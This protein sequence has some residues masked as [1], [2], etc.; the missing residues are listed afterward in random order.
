MK[1]YII[2]GEASGDLHA[3]NL[4]KEIRA[5]DEHAE[6]RCW[7]GD[8]MQGQGGNLMKHY[9][10]LA[11]M[12]FLEVALN[13]RKIIGNLDF[14]RKDIMVW[15]PDAVI[16]VDYPGFNL[17]IAEFCHKQGIKVFYYIS[18]QVWAWKKSRIKNIVRDVDRLFVI[19][20]FEKKFYKE[21]HYDVDFVGHPL[22][23]A[24]DGSHEKN[25]SVAFRTKHRLDDRKIIALLPGSRKQEISKILPIM[26]QAMTHFPDFQ[27]VV[28]GMTV[29]E[30]AL[31]EKYSDGHPLKVI[32]NSTYDLLQNCDAAAVTSGT[33]SLEAALLNVPQVICYKGS[34]ISF[35]IARRI[36]NVKYIGLPNLVLD[37]EIVT[38]LIQND[39]SPE[40][41]K[42]NIHKLLYDQDV[43]S[44][45]ADDYELLK[46]KLGGPGAS[47]RTAELI[48]HYLKSAVKHT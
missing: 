4:M 14:C 39:L 34:P 6:F 42:E 28:A 47:A 41:L 27:A 10:D 21:Y 3:A 29:N 1:Y 32:Y 16:L 33:A 23:D 17:R 44:H 30:P 11:F 40:N 37:R 36:V 18:P 19:L 24:L 13:I 12:G 22:L 7:G 48:L 31:Y 38:E 35:A 2:A 25:D 5:R 26:L 43:R 15:R 46:K 8:K 20:P 9:R 45:L